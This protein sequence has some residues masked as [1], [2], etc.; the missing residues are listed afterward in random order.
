MKMIIERLKVDNALGFENVGMSC[1]IDFTELDAGLI[2]L[3][4]ENGA[5]KTT[6]MEMCHPWTYFP[7]RKGFTEHFTGKEAGKE[8]HVRMSNGTQY[9]FVIKVNADAN[10]VER[11][12]Y[13]NGQAIN[14]GK[15][16]SYDE[17][18][19]KLFGDR[20]AYFKTAFCTQKDA[21]IGAMT[22]GERRK[23]IAEMCDL[24]KLQQI[25]DM[26]KGVVREKTDL[27]K[28][29][30][31]KHAELEEE[32][33]PL[34]SL[35]G[36][37]VQGKKSLE[38]AQ[39][40]SSKLADELETHQANLAELQGQKA[41]Q[42]AVRAQIGDLESEA[43]EAGSQYSKRNT[44]LLNAIEANRG[45]IRKY[46]KD[47]TQY[48][49]LPAM[50]E[51][52]RKIELLDERADIQQSVREAKAELKAFQTTMKSAQASIDECTSKRN[53][54][55][56]R[57]E[58][59]VNHCEKMVAP[60]AEVPCQ[61]LEGEYGAGFAETV[62]KACKSC[63]FISM[64]IKAKDDLRDYQEQLSEARDE[65]NSPVPD[66]LQRNF[67]VA[68]QDVLKCTE[69][70]EGLQKEL[71]ASRFDS[72]GDDLPALK[73]MQ[74][75][76]RNGE[77]HMRKLDD[78]IRE[79]KLKVD[80]DE[81]RLEELKA[82]A[83]NGI[84]KRKEKMAELSK[85]VID[86]LDL[87]VQEVQRCVTHT[88]NQIERLAVGI[89]NHEKTISRLKANIEMLEGKAELSKKTNDD[90][91]M[92]RETV[93]SWKKLWEAFGKTGIQI[94]K[95]ESAA[96]EI[97]EEAN[98]ILEMFDMDFNLTI[99]TIRPSKDGKTDIECFEIMIGNQNGQKK[100]DYLSGGQAIWVDTALRIALAIFRARRSGQQF[101]TVFYDEKDGALSP[102]N[103]PAYYKA[104]MHGH[105]ASGSHQT[106]MVTHRQ[107]MQDRCEQ[108]LI[109]DTEG[110]RIC[111][112]KDGD[113][114]CQK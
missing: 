46:K 77:T 15:K 101:R 22:D 28:E 73:K 57:L 60:L 66:I 54:E 48:E 108:K 23:L 30:L 58:Q 92:L 10:K 51:I 86:D 17:I 21:G 104:I 20:D 34:Q 6:L 89:M 100:I 45:L 50:E 25:S 33:M 49:G 103:V 81:S 52:E 111:M 87:K 26:A 39:Q 75:M 79:C 44:E 70:L 84:E 99:E 7:S 82:E 102:D 29:K 5:G 1:D 71:A 107:E 13:K 95:I 62:S 24:D 114:R 47:K 14:D 72:I 16:E 61:N 53:A 113:L 59:H 67:D 69:R 76:V 41:V 83:D 97:T 96:P 37:L 3:I 40:A 31:R 64:S 91:R 65:A 112:D 85:Q 78:L 90:I 11:Y 8:L 56:K 36:Q 32:I 27:L 4:G 12:V 109:L 35:K 63:E 43:R 19:A 88:K 9:A 68:K 2:A 80:S 98:T 105:E 93:S 18:V 38:E 106:I 74:A 94:Y 110:Q 42:D 55:V